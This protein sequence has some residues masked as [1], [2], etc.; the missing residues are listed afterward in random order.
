MKNSLVW[1]YYSWD[2]I[3]NLKYNPFR[4][5]GNVSLQMYFMTALSIIWT[6]AF[7]TMIAGLANLLPLIYGHMGVLFAIFITYGTFKD[8]DEDGAV[9]F[10]TWTRDYKRQSLKDRAKNACKWDL[11]NEA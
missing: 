1:F 8:A 3:M 6:L 11:E 10:Q 7:C 4:F 2:S 9:W 5:I